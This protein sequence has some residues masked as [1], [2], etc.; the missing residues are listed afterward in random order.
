MINKYYIIYILWY[1]VYLVFFSSLPM[2]LILYIYQ[3]K[4][5]SKISHL[6][7]LHLVL[8]DAKWV[9]GVEEHTTNAADSLLVC[10]WPLT[11][12]ASSMEVLLT[13]H[14]DVLASLMWVFYSSQKHVN[15]KM[16]GIERNICKETGARK[17]WPQN[18]FPSCLIFYSFSLSFS[19]Y[20][21]YIYLNW[22]SK[23]LFVTWCI[24]PLPRRNATSLEV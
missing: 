18:F 13:P 21:Y 2:I 7:L 3:N 4:L 6:D 1:E 17:L 8:L 10:A 11:Q 19:M 20:T 16:E 23:N 9:G 12:A 5:D 15:Y 24:L 22:L 14:C